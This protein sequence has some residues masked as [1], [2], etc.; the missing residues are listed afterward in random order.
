MSPK[1]KRA[2]VIGP[3]SAG[4]RWRSGCRR[5][6]VATTLIEARDKP[7]RPALLLAEGRLHLRRRA[8]G[9]HRPGLPA[10]AVG[11]DGHDM[12]A[13]F[14]LMPSLPFYARAWPDGTT[15]TTR[16]D[17]RSCR[18]RDRPL[19]PARLL[20]GYDAFLEYS[21]GGLSR[22]ATVKA[23]A[24]CRSSIAASMSR[25]APDACDSTRRLALGLSDVGQQATSRRAGCARR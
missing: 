18:P 19:D 16:T 7:G 24:P 9:D 25:A 3:G 5:R 14:E 20:P 4:S 1:G 17:W 13:D 8:D 23:R 6:A 11:A 12:A 22:K 2:C 21:A 10:R 15:S